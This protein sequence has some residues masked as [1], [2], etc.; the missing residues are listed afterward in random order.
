VRCCYSSQIKRGTMM[1][2]ELE[3][4]SHNLWEWEPFPAQFRVKEPRVYYRDARPFYTCIVLSTVRSWT[5]TRPQNQSHI[6]QKSN[7]EVKEGKLN[8]LTL[9]CLRPLLGGIGPSA[10]WPEL[11]ESMTL[12]CLLLQQLGT[13][14]VHVRPKRSV[15]GASEGWAAAGP[16]GR[17][18]L[19]LGVLCN[20]C[21]HDST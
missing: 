11:S 19:P 2:G 3:L 21:C 15:R 4:R 17:A 20:L 14:E 1:C 16:T 9:V 13:G 5:L 12:M 10:L 8:F 7:E 18:L 6:V